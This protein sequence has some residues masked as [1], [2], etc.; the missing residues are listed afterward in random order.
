MH[1]SFIST[2]PDYAVPPLYFVP[3]NITFL[4]YPGF[5]S[6]RSFM[7][8]K[9]RLCLLAIIF[10]DEYTQQYSLLSV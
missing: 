7:E 8:E 3:L 9:R 2:G 6:N 4:V 1:S 5:I 10:I